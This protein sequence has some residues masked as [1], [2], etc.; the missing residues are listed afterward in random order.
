MDRLLNI[1][2]IVFFLA[3]LPAWFTDCPAAEDGDAIIISAEEIRAMNALK[4]ADVLNHVPGIRAGD[5]S[6]GIH[7]SYK[8]KVFMD[9]RP[10]NDPS[11]S[12]NGV[13]WDLVSPDDVE[14]IEILR[15]KGSLTYG[16]DASGGVI[17][18]T[19]K[20]INKLQ[21]N[22]KIYG[23][24]FG[25]E[26]YRVNSK[27]S[28]GKIGLGGNVGYETGRGYK[29]NNDKERWQAG[30]KLAYTIDRD[31]SISLS[32]DY[33]EDERGL[34]GCPDYP[35]PFSRKKSRMSSNA[36]LVKWFGLTSN[37]FFNEAFRHNTDSSRNLDKTIR[38]SELG[39]DLTSFVS[40]GSWGDLNY[41]GG[42]HQTRASGSSFADQQEHTF[43]VFGSQSLPW[44]RYHLTF[45]MGI[46]A[47][48]NS[49]FDNT[50]NPEVKA[51]YKHNDWR[52]STAYSRTN[53]LPSFYQRYNETS[54]TRPNPDLG[55]ETADNF[56]LSLFRQLQPSISGSISFFYNM[57]TDRI[58]Y[59]LGDNG[60]GR[61]E[62][63]GRVTYM[64]GDL[65]MGWQIHKTFNIKG[66][67]TYM[68]AT[69]KDTDLWLPCKAGHTANL[70]LYWQPVQPLSI[71]LTTTYVSSVFL[72]KN[73]TRTVPEYTLTDT[74]VEYAFTHFSLF[75]EVKN[76]FDKKYYWSD[77]FLGPP[78]TWLA[79]VNYKF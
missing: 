1:W 3:L 69:D 22:V 44:H 39:E 25:V 30:I 78:R 12:H 8:V 24:G 28:A 10:I 40:M 31:R 18:I 27:V 20:S 11:S 72:N 63:F 29:I 61:Y 23:G 2:T 79:G 42:F 68:E 73:N 33:L 16:Q 53:N 66:S 65:A 36:L 37:T 19:T 57:L 75:G 35:T 70:D 38:V 51:V 74:R 14:R 15:G 34:S 49:A 13:N 60:V 77:G 7:G 76:I 6:V 48:F 41:G 9:G 52:L 43:F 54:S 64:G 4:M 50:V 5:S 71:V 55:M 67:Y 26:N 21:G 58:T 59:V 47:N 46:R 56:S 32:N 17:L 62:N 45:S